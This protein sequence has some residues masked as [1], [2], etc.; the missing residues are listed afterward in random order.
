MKSYKVFSIFILILLQSCNSKTDLEKFKFDTDVSLIVK[1]TTQ[2]EKG[3]DI[4][5]PLLSYQTYKIKD[6]SYGKINFTDYNI[7]DTAKN[8]LIKYESSL[9]LLVDDYKSNK[10]VGYAIRIEK[11]DEGSNLF[12]YIKNKLGK[13]LKQ[14][15]Y[16]KD[17]HV[18]SSYLWDD[19]KRNQLIYIKQNT[20]YFSGHKNRFISTEL[21]FFK[22]GITFTP[23][24]GNNPE[25]IKKLL[26]ENPN[27]FD[28][29]E[30]LKSR[31]Y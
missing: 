23:D 24:E 13:P 7:K 27:A 2:F 16:N 6:Y 10:L 5:F 1:D 19:K 22:R 30:I 18:Q 9:S 4:I 26:E 17:N 21:A 29:L 15:I 31:F 14:N 20:E 28:V 11:E 8:S 12:K 3:S 25:N